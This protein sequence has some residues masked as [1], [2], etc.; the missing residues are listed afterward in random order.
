[1]VFNLILGIGCAQ[2]TFYSLEKC[3]C[4][5]ETQKVRSKMGQV[6]ECIFLAQNNC[7][8][9][10]HK[11]PVISRMFSLTI[12]FYITFFDDWYWLRTDIVDSITKYW[13]SCCSLNVLRSPSLFHFFPMFI[14]NKLILIYPTRL[15]TL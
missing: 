15:H 5:Y 4:W 14:Q 2:V 10:N 8:D 13:F 11:L 1:M 3:L 12:V 7:W 6:Q 9:F